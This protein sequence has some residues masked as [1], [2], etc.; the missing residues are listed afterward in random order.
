[1]SGL[2]HNGPLSALE[3]EV[4]KEIN[5]RRVD[6]R[7][8]QLARLAHQQGG[9]VESI[10][11]GAEL[12]RGAGARERELLFDNLVA[13]GAAVLVEGRDEAGHLKRSTGHTHTPT[14]NNTP[15]NDT[16]TRR[17]QHPKRTPPTST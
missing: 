7:E 4:E 16:H 11:L 17:E 3:T 15:D 10:G 12:A 14:E 6:K 13:R 8:R 9:K 2:L 5:I 1:V